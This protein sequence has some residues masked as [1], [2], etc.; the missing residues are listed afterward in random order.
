MKVRKQI[1]LDPDTGKNLKEFAIL[2]GRT[3]TSIIREAVKRYIEEKQKEY[4]EK[5]NPLS[6]VIGL[7]Q[8]GKEDASFNH[9]RY[10]YKKDKD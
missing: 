3:E 6:K 10:L 8:Q 4:K 7:C 9:D 1:Y 5:V 2:M